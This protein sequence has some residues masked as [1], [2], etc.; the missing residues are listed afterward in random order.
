M[1]HAGMHIIMWVGLSNISFTNYHQSATEVVD[2]L[3][4]PMQTI[5]KI[6]KFSQEIYDTQMD[7][8]FILQGNI[9]VSI[10]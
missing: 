3:W 7:N 4:K 5:K 6:L 10:V 2:Y 8:R 1:A 9:T